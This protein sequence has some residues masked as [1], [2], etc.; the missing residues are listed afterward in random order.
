[1]SY[2]FSVVLIG[3]LIFLHELGHLLAAKAVGIPIARFSIGFGPVLWSRRAGGVEYCLSAIPLGGYVLPQI[4]SEEAFFALPTRRRVVFWLGGPAANFI[5]AAIMLAVANAI[6]QGATIWGTLVEPVVQVAALTGQLL[7]AIPAIFMRP[8]QLSGVVGIVAVG[9]SMFDDGTL[10]MLR[11]A[12][13]LNLN[14]AVFN[15]LPIAPLDGGKIL[16][17]LLEKI[18]PRLARLQT[19][20][21]VA[22]LMLLVALMLY[23]TVLDVVRHAA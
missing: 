9:K 8:D 2:L 1:V 4:E 23:T 21:A 6:A 5:S 13:L 20:F 22:G 3:F 15:L 17:A 7:A 10:A 16:G 12:V 19:G 11:F 18:H 14:L